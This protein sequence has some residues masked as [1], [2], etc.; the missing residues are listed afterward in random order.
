MSGIVASQFAAGRFVSCRIGGRPAEQAETTYGRATTL[1]PYS[2][3]T[4]ELERARELRWSSLSS[5]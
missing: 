4:R 2:P 3:G 1:E 5:H